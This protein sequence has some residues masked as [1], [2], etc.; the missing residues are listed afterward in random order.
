MRRLT[1]AALTA[2][3]LAA[4]APAFAADSMALQ[5][6][7]LPD[8][9]FAGYFV[10]AAKGFYRK[11]EL[12][13]T[14][15]PGGPNVN[16]SQVLASGGADVA[17]DWLASALA[18]RDRGAPIVNIAQIFQHSG[19]QLTCRRDSGVRRPADLKGKTLGV[20]FAGNEYP[21]LAWMAKLGLATSGDRPDVTVL[22]QDAGV[23]LLLER[24][25]AC[26]STMSYNEYWQV[27]DGGMTPSQLV[28]FRYDDEGVA[29]LED[30]LYGL[31]AKVA[32]P[33]MRDRLARFVRAS[34]E[35]WRFA[36]APAHRA[37]AVRIVVQ[38]S[39]GDAAD[40][41]QA[42]RMLRE[43]A[44]LVANDRHG[45]GYLEPAAYERTVDVLLSAASNPVIRKRPEG[46][47]THEIWD[48]AFA[49]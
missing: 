47:W 25:A 33:A 28:V 24:R 37:E 26:I 22:R 12:D 43:V 19:L 15:K 42:E 32:D 38:H 29:T 48:R 35:G 8:A 18:A 17:V 34:V 9:Q 14:I 45:L 3:C 11:A 23:E 27:I 31:S 10:A 21:F 49:R 44:K 30:G 40:P 46:A 39:A 7:W 41:R 2:L 1:C 6:K 20:W 5:L 4:V 36:T 16:P 13:V